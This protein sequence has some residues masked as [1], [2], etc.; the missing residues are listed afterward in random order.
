MNDYIV[1]NSELSAL[2][3]FSHS[4]LCYPHFSDEETEIGRSYVDLPYIP[5]LGIH[6][7][8]FEP[9]WSVPELSACRN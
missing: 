4:G 6:G 7:V 1:P 5:R 8:E 2:H 9:Q 3:D